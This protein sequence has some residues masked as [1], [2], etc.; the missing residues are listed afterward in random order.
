MHLFSF[1]PS[2]E[3]ATSEIRT[4]YDSMF[5]VGIFTPDSRNNLDLL[6]PSSSA[7]CR[8]N[9]ALCNVQVSEICYNPKN[10]GNHVLFLMTS[11]TI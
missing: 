8:I 6:A 9:P 7:N 4:E 11:K 2:Q 1:Y 10:I 5:T 3:A